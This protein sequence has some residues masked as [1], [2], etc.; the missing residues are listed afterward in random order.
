MN[1]KKIQIV[2]HPFFFIVRYLVYSRL[3][4]SEH[5]VREMN[6]TLPW[7]KLVCIVWKPESK[8]I[9]NISAQQEH[10]LKGRRLWGARSPDYDPRSHTAYG[11]Q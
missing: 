6:Q 11:L 10:Q 7:L 8:D 1:S 5:F 4:F 9:I 3:F 2:L